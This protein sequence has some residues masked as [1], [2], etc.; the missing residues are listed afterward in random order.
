M[1]VVEENECA[2]I[3]DLRLKVTAEPSGLARYMS[4]LGMVNA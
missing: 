4:R 1:E 3:D 2:E